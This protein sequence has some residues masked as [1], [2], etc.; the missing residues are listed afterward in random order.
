MESLDPL[1]LDLPVLAALAG[2]AANDHL[3]MRLHDAGFAG[4]R[5]SHGYVIQL[6]VD[7]RPTVGELAER[8]G[9]SQQAVSKTVAELESLGVVE[10]TADERDRR[11]TRVA[12]TARGQAVLDRTRSERQAL[13][14]AVHREVGD[15]AAAKQALAALLHHSGGRAAVQ[16]RRAK[17][18][19]P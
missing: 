16:Q 8:L 4:I 9:V 14:A 13:E 7:A 17:P 18:P 11:V 3:L 5:V 19:S 6:L 1:A 2:T 15:L 12:L 10:R